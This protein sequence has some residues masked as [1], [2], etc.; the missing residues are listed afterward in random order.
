MCSYVEVTICKSLVMWIMFNH[1]RHFHSRGHVCWMFF[2]LD[3]ILQLEKLY[4]LAIRKL[5]FHLFNLIF[6]RCLPGALL[7]NYPN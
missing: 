6:S 3:V 2:N 5:V 4:S 1:D 7:D